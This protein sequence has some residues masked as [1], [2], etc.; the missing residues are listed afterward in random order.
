MQ[1]KGYLYTVKELS[2]H[3]R[4]ATGGSIVTRFLMLTGLSKW[5]I[6]KATRLL[7]AYMFAKIFAYCM[8]LVEYKSW[9]DAHRMKQYNMAQQLTVKCMCHLNFNQSVSLIEQHRDSSTDEFPT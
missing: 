5:Y 3:Q 8:K 9:Y 7:H 2:A 6:F 4:N 1:T